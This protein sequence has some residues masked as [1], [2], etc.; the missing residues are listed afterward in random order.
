MNVLLLG[1]SGLLGTAL[2]EAA[3]PTATLFV[4]SSA[5]LDITDAGAVRRAIAEHR[6][7]LILVAAGLADVEAAETDP[8]WATTLNATAVGAIAQAAAAKQAIVVLPST[9]EVFSGAGRTPWREVDRPDPV[10]TYAR[11]K[12]EGERLLLMSGARA[13]VVRSG[14]LYGRGGNGFVREMCER[15]RAGQS[16]RVA[17]DQWS[18]PTSADDLARWIWALVA[19]NATGIVHAA[20]QG[21]TTPADVARRVYARYGFADGV[22]PVHTTDLP[23][24]APRPRYGVLDCSWFDALV[25]GVR[26]PWDEV[27]VEYLRAQP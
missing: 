12:R 25:P 5:A 15:A 2:R 4:P 21:E 19:R 10:S 18:A 11:T 16:V 7:E 20:A 22:E 24:R 8:D 23:L 13:L 1:G 3:P 27:L 26:R 17:D 14:W 9:F 6:A